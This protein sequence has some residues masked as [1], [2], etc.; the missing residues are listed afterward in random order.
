MRVL[1][2]SR[3]L[4]IGWGA[5]ALSHRYAQITVCRVFETQAVMDDFLGLTMSASNFLQS[6]CLSSVTL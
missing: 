1:L 6:F 3:G 2:D 4:T 5:G